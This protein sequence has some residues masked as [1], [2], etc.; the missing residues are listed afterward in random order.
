VS[1]VRPVCATSSHSA[2]VSTLRLDTPA[3]RAP[4][5][6]ARGSVQ[7]QCAAV[8]DKA[9]CT[10]VAPMKPLNLMARKSKYNQVVYRLVWFIS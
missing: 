9:S 3:F 7:S 4:R 5:G 1:Q 2:A 6:P 10:E 8:N